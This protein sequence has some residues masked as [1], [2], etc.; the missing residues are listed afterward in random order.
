[1]KR[2]VVTILALAVSIAFFLAG[3]EEGSPSQVVE[4]QNDV[5][6]GAVSGSISLDETI[7]T[8]LDEHLLAPNFGGKVFTAHKI[9]GDNSDEIYVWAYAMEFYKQNKSLRKGTGQSGPVVLNIE[10]QNG[11]RVKIASHKQPRDGSLYIQDI[12][13]MFPK[14]VQDAI[15]NIQQGQTIPELS[16]QAEQR[17]RK[18]FDIEGIT[19]EEII[20]EQIPKPFNPVIH[21]NK[22][23]FKAR[24]KGNVMPGLIQEMKKTGWTELKEEQQGAM[25]YF[26]K[27]IKGQK[28][29]ISVLPVERGGPQEKD[30][31]TF[32]YFEIVRE[33]T[34]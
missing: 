17:A 6:T 28:I 30:A 34:M 26:A 27:E 12:K 33:G 8:Y 4:R 9:L 13:N 25:Q 15:F 1:M 22:L 31:T 32:V 11:Q 10:A 20:K 24:W 3:C 14:K 23:E 2:W 29:R 16:Y 19:I 7:T 5:E 21:A 18:W